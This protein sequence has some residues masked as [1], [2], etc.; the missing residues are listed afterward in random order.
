MAMCPARLD[1]E[2]CY[3]PTKVV[4]IYLLT[5]LH[6]LEQL[7]W[8]ELGQVT[9]AHS[10]VRIRSYDC[11]S[12]DLAAHKGFCGLARSATTSLFL[13]PF[14]FLAAPYPIPC[15]VDNGNKRGEGR[16]LFFSVALLADMLGVKTMSH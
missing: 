2:H 10:V 9:G 7:G 4:P 1:M 16:S 11:W 5:F 13:T 3:L 12:S 6:A 8:Q 14:L 15:A